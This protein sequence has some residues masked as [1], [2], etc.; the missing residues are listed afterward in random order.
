MKAILSILINIV[1]FISI[2]SCSDDGFEIDESLLIG[3]EHWLLSKTITQLENGD[4]QVLDYEGACNTNGLT[5]ICWKRLSWLFEGNNV[6]FFH[7]FEGNCMPEFNT[8][9]YSIDG[10]K[11]ILDNQEKFTVIFLSESQLTLES[12]DGDT[13]YKLVR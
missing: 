6:T 9:G 12:S 3:T 10:S 1:F 7:C 4:N 2:T 13:T 11:I 5:V 8:Y